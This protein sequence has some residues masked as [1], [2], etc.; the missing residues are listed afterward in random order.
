MRF[1]GGSVDLEHLQRQFCGSFASLDLR[2]KT[3]FTQEAA[4]VSKLV[5]DFGQ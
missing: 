1:F 2:L 5:N 4:A 3:S